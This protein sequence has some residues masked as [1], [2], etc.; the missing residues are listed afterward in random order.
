MASALS[1]GSEMTMKRTDPQDDDPL[2]R[3]LIE[4]FD[5]LDLPERCEVLDF[6]RGPARR[7]HATAPGGALLA[8]A[9]TFAAD[10]VA[11]IEQAISAACETVDPASW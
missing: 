6:S 7:R 3:D 1:R 2:T 4:T 8:F 9:G 10:D 11:R 5:A